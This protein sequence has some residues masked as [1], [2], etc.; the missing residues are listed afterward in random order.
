[1]PDHPK[2]I[3]LGGIESL[4]SLGT[5]SCPLWRPSWQE[6]SESDARCFGSRCRQLA[7]CMAQ[8]P[9]LH[10]GSNRGSKE[11]PRFHPFRL[12]K[13]GESSLP[14]AQRVHRG[15]LS[16]RFTLPAQILKHRREDTGIRG[17]RNRR[18]SPDIIVFRPVAVG[19]PI[20][21]SIE[22]IQV[23][24]FLRPPSLKSDYRASQSFT[25]CQRGSG[26]ARRGSGVAAGAHCGNDKAMPPPIFTEYV[27][28]P[29]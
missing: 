29:A 11:V 13:L 21:G 6:S 12:R 14:R 23:F 16:D 24:A 18:R 1:M 4:P 9:L 22:Y 26:A 8:P 15:K 7:Q 27:A 20:G 19:A 25:A 10:N 3:R 2:I 5:L 28:N 17:Y